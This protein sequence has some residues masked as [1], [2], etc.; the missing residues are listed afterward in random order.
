N[1][2]IDEITCEALGLRLRADKDRDSEN[3]TAKAQKQCPL[4]MRQKPQRN[5][6]RRRHGAFGG[7]G[8]L[9]IR[10]RTVSPG[11]NLSWSETITRLPSSKPLV[12]SVK[13]SVRNPIPTVRECT[14]PWFTMS[15]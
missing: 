10:C 7:G 4:A 8:E 2:A 3:D 12:T 5:I 13:S 1:G 11:W 6:K 14:M 9:I 15:A